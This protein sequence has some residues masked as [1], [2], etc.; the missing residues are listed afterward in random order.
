[1]FDPKN[2]N[3]KTPDN[4][5]YYIINTNHSIDLDYSDNFGE[6]VSLDD[7]RLAVG[8]AN[9]RGYNNI[10]NYSVGAV[11]LFS[12]ANDSFLGCTLE[13][14]IGEGYTG[15]KNINIDLDDLDDFGGAVSLDGTRLAVGASSGAGYENA[16]GSTGEVYLFSFDDLAFNNGTLQA[17]IGEDYT[18]GKNIDIDLDNQDYFGSS[19]SLDG[20]SLVV[21]AEG[22]N[23]FNNQTVAT[24]AAYLISFTDNAFSGGQVVGIIGDGYT[25]G[26]NLNIDLDNTDN[27]GS[28]VSFD[29]NSLAIGSRR[30]DGDSN[31]TQDTGA[32]YLIS[33]TDANFNGGNLQGIIGDN[34]TGGNSIDLSVYNLRDWYYSIGFSDYFGCSVSLNNNRLAVGA[35]G[36]DNGKNAAFNTG[37]V[38]LFTFSDGSFNN[39]SLETIIGQCYMD[40]KNR[41][42][43]IFNNLE[44]DDQ[45]GFSVSLDDKQL[46]IGAHRDSGAGGSIG[47]DNDYFEGAVYLFE[48]ATDNFSGGLERGIIGEDYLYNSADSVSRDGNRLVVGDSN[49]DGYDDQIYSN[50]GAV[51]LYS[52]SQND[53]NIF[54][55]EGI[56]GRGFSGGKNIN[57]TLDLNDSFG[58][59][60]SLDN[61]QLAVGARYDDGLNNAFYDTGAV[62]LYTFTDEEYNGGSLQ[63]VIGNGYTNGKNI[64][65]NVENWDQLGRAVSLDNNRLAIGCRRRFWL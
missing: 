63:S 25:G 58:I 43:M 46:A 27:F 24:G 33:F 16:Q 15:G 42:P 26:K 62:Y 50:S 28:A 44:N 23:G 51:Y 40:I 64:N 19:V 54:T 29:G 52:F 41:Q 32:V 17:M 22:D 65:L 35:Y 6:A 18:G 10:E 31:V 3:I 5:E 36:D 55:L 4:Y 56:I 57:Q 9:D 2:I 39:G 34:Y 30:D 53:P 11:Y 37:A 59:A 38:Y 21:G 48:F 7:N 14:I 61:K 1:M 45:F 12:F 20:N 47:Y 13:G 60:V 8:S 49:A